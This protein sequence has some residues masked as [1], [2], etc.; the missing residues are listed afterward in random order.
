MKVPKAIAIPALLLA[1]LQSVPLA[2]SSPL[3]FAEL[4]GIEN[5]SAKQQQQ[6]PQQQ[7][8][9]QQQP[10]Q[11][12]PVQQQPVQ[13]QPGQQQPV[14]QQPGQQQPSQ[15]QPLHTGP[16]TPLQSVN[17]QQTLTQ[18]LQSNSSFTIFNSILNLTNLNSVSCRSTRFMQKPLCYLLTPRI[19]ITCSLHFQRQ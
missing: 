4:F 19:L 18:A 8:P 10:T 7:Q 14:Q 11:Q 12:Q 3:S 5:V 17:Q 6:Q 1:V 15:Q 9:M 13:Q 16:P 2:Q